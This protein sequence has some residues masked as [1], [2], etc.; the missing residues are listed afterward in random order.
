MIEVGKY[1]TII[2][3][4][5]Y[6]CPAQVNSVESQK[7]FKGMMPTFT[8]EVL[9]VYSGPPVVAFRWRHWGEM[10]NDYVGINKFVQTI[11]PFYLTDQ[12]SSHSKG[13]QVKLKAHGGKIEIPGV[14]VAHVDEKVRLRKADTWFDP[15]EI[16]RQ[17]HSAGS[18]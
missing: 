14:T 2:P 18:R 13:Q 15:L 12:L 8:W 3:S 10:K 11:R 6:Y 9:E 4:N 7:V 16:F 1:N 17:K 5:E